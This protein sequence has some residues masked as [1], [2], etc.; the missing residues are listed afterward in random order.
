MLSKKILEEIRNSPEKI[1]DMINKIKGKIE[2]IYHTYEGLENLKQF[3][4]KSVLWAEDIFHIFKNSVD[5]FNQ[6]RLC[7]I[8]S[9]AGTFDLEYLILFLLQFYLLEV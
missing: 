6:H 2:S 9:N 4:E 5:H 1:T 8:E 7:G 3:C